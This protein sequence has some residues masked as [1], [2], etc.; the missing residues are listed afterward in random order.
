MMNLLAIVRRT[1]RGYTGYAEVYAEGG[2]KWSQSTRIV[3]LTRE[4]ARHDAQL[5][6]SEIAEQN[7]E[8]TP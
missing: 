4:D 3:R 6:A 2:K 8:T 5:L 7:Q 1:P